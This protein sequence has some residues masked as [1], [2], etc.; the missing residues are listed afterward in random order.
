MNHLRPNDPTNLLS[1][2][3]KEDPNADTQ[4]GKQLERRASF[5]NVNTKQKSV[6][7]KADVKTGEIQ[8]TKAKQST[9]QKQST[10]EQEDRG[11]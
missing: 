9:N 7:T 5:N 1:R 4:A 3:D 10:K 11:T 2:L 6:A 8:E